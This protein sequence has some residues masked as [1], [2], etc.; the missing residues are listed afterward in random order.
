MHDAEQNVFDENDFYDAFKWDLKKTEG[1]LLIQSPFLAIRK[2]NNLRPQ[3]ESLIDRG[4]RVCV[5]AQEPSGWK[6]HQQFSNPEMKPFEGAMELLT[7]LGVHVSLRPRIHEKLVVIDDRILWE[8]SLNVL[9]HYDSSERMTRWVDRA[10]VA[11]TISKFKLDSCDHCLPL[12]DAWTGEG[13][14]ETEARKLQFIGA[15]IK[16]RRIARR[17]TQDGLAAIAGLPQS[18]ISGVEI[19][20][21][22]SRMSTLIQICDAL[23]MQMVIAPRHCLPAILQRL[24]TTNNKNQD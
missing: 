23:G 12:P 16:R 1:L 4:V 9:S 7:Q 6:Q 10:L 19:G 15:C 24:E 22:N 18:T 17:L 11:K 5:F 3:L 21:R 13:G 2:I 14:A 20:S 8:G